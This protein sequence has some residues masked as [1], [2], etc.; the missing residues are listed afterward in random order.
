ME[1]QRPIAPRAIRAPRAAQSVR[2]LPSRPAS[3]NPGLNSRP[4][5]ASRG[6][7]RRLTR[8]EGQHG[9][10]ARIHPRKRADGFSTRPMPEITFSGPRT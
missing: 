7:R 5:R 8:N 4:S 2:P 9:S 3:I 10:P 1:K 6:D